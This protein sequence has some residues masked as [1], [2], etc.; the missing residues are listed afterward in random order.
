M[1]RSFSKEV[2]SYE[3]EL[4]KH[5][6]QLRKERA[7]TENFLCHISTQDNMAN[8]EINGVNLAAREATQLEAARIAAEAARRVAEETI[9]DGGGQ[10][11]NLN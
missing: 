4:E 9:E 2:I 11:F 10:R 1:T 3:P 8:Q 7:L 6:Q 5:L